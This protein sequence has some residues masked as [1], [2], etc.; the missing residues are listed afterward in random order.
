MKTDRCQCSFARCAKFLFS[1]RPVKNS[2]E[3]CRPAGLLRLLL[4]HYHPQRLTHRAADH[5]AQHRLDPRPGCPHR[6]PQ[7]TGYCPG[8]WPISSSPKRA[9]SVGGVQK[10][11]HQ[12][13]H[14][15]QGVQHRRGQSS[16][17]VGDG[18]APVDLVHGPENSSPHRCPSGC[19]NDRIYKAQQYHRAA[20]VARQKQGA[21]PGLDGRV[22]ADTAITPPKTP[23]ARGPSIMALRPPAPS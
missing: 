5:A 22:K 4:L 19:G 16:N 9:W 21:E 18:L 13:R 14:I 10:D 12:H 15:E 3:T 20:G 17:V 8:T 1:G 7:T 11:D 2:E 23:P 6:R